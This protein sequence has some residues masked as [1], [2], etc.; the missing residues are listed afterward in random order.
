MQEYD[1]KK[2][3]EKWAKYWVE[4]KSYK[5]EDFSEKPKFY[6]LSEFFGP[7]GKG[8]HLGHVKCFTPTD[9]IARYM[10]FKGYNVLY[11][12]GWDAFGLPTEN[13][14][15]KT[16]EQPIAVTE[17]N[18]QKFKSQLT[19]M[20]YSFDWDREIGTSDEDYYKWTQWIF[21]QLYNNGLAYKA[22]GEVNFC[23]QCK[24]VLSNE[25]S[26]GGLC[27][28]CHGEVVRRQ[29]DVWY[30]KMQSYSDKMLEDVENID[31]KESLKDSQRNWIGRSV[32]AEIVFPIKDSE[33]GLKVFTTRPDTIYG[34][35]FMVIAPEHP[36]TKS[37]KLKNIDEVNAYKAEAS[38]KSSIERSANK[39]KTGVRLDGITALNPITNKEIPVY[40]S[41]YVMM[42]YGTGAIMAVPAHDDR[43]Y[44]FAKKFGIP[45]V[46][47]IEGGDISESA[48]TG[49]GVHINSGNLN[50]LGVKEAISLMIETLEKMGC[51]HEMVNYKMQDW[52]FNRQ[53]YWGEPF[54]IV[55]CDECGIVPLDEKDLP[56][57]LPKTDDFIPNE[58]GASP[59]SKLSDWVNCKCPKC[60]KPAV[61]ETDTMPN[62]AGSSWYWLRYLDPK[63]DKEFVSQDKLNYWGQVDLYTGGVE[64]VTRHMLY[65]SFW[66]N[67]LY[68]IGKVPNKTAFKRRMCNGLVLDSEG[69]K[70]SKSSGNA[71]D[72]I[73]VVSEYGADTFRLHMMFIGE[74]EKNNN[75][76]L[77]GIT[78][79]KRFL[80]GVWSL[81]DMVKGD[82]VSKEHEFILHNLIKRCDTT[83]YDANPEHTSYEQHNDF[84]FNTVIANMMTF[85]NKI[86]EDGWITKE[87]LR[88]FL[89]LLNP[90]APFITAELYE[91]VFGGDIVNEKFPE[92]DESKTVTS[93]VEIP[94]QVKGKRKAV[95]NISAVAEESEALAEAVKAIGISADD[96]KKVIYKQ[97]KIIN[98]IV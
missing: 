20:G 44:E 98:L 57:V 18:V 62:W 5:A 1:F 56:L 76:T 24:T 60:G 66:N 94:V 8:I 2:I 36:L 55:F 29:R 7:N 46:Q 61:R 15:I 37:D 97:G 41:D 96:V 32:G 52:P 25:D 14:A 13:Y 27:D 92:F 33:E 73:D 6:V 77:K 85:M 89:V 49:D 75:W 28:R 34:V 65:A 12:A 69:K 53:R 81:Q 88:S 38:K 59:L 21:L 72:P 19:R 91:I 84:K 68:D 30:L 42:D 10:R 82:E 67:F 54:P 47:V 4:K 48:Y 86:R 70:M 31:M 35:T 78:G 51:G 9:I 87:E 39:D 16:G 64:H 43:D 79:I 83:I 26:Q 17:R 23:P 63:N 50:N 90:F 40:I 95:I 71:I 11:P 80:N 3:E 45:I 74:Y 58:T 22:S 93:T